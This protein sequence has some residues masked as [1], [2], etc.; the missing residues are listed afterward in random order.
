[1]E[2]CYND[3]HNTSKDITYKIFKRK[4]VCKEFFTLLPR[5]FS[6]SNHRLPKDVG[7]WNNLERQEIVC[8]LCNKN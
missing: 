8:N 2:K 6:T 4:F 5:K 3:M 7:R 1:M